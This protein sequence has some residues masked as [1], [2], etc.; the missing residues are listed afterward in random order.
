MVDASEVVDFGT[1]AED[2]GKVVVA[3]K[4]VVVSV[5]VLSDRDVVDASIFNVRGV[6]VKSKVV[7]TSLV[8]FVSDIVVI[9]PLVVDVGFVDVGGV[10]V[11]VKLVVSSVV[12]VVS[13]RVVVA[14]SDC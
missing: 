13:D 8:F 1:T 14:A 7:V 2:V 9:G 12:V 3:A 5:V 6:G 10:I 11:E 4:G